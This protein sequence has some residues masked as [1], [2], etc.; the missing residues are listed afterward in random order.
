MPSEI[1]WPYAAGAVVALAGLLRL[2]DQAWSA[3]W[4]EKV[5]ALG[6]L[7]VAVP[8]AVF[9]GEHFASAK[10]LMQMVPKW[11]PGPLF[12]TYFVG[13]ALISAA[14]SFALQQ[15]EGWSAPLLSLMLFLFVVLISVP[16]AR[17]NPR[18]RLTWALLLRDLSFS[19]GALAFAGTQVHIWPATAKKMAIR[20][21]QTVIAVTTIF[22][23]LMQLL[24][25]D[26]VPGV[27]LEKVTP[28]WIPGRIFW[29]YFAGVVFLAAGA[30]L[31]ANRRTRLAATALGAMVVVLVV[32][33]YLPFWAANLANIEG[34]NY[35]FDTLMFGGAM[36]LLAQA[37]PKETLSHV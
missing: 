27:P 28:A 10:D 35:F 7:F 9:S 23:G 29:S 5:V 4:R 36:L 21:G 34:P 3:D 16:A 13:V 6:P 11:I 1:F 24:H 20:T 18:D 32:F 2:R 19:A 31:L 12:W 25:P 26:H 14:T 17:E 30:G 15:K 37:M 33:V 8:L 22:Y